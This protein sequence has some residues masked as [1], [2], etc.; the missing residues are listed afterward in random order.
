MA[1][2]GRIRDRRLCA[3]AQ[4]QCDSS[5]LSAGTLLSNSVHSAKGRK[6]VDKLVGGSSLSEGTAN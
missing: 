6:A 4:S 3:L 1:E 5:D 2:S